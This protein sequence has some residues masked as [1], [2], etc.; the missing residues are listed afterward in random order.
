MAARKFPRTK[1]DAAVL[2]DPADWQSA[3]LGRTLWR[4]QRDILRSVLTH[5]QTA[6][7]G[8]HGS[9]KTFAA[10]GL[11]LYWLTRWQKRD[12]S[13]RLKSDGKIFNTA[14]TMRQVKLLWE[15]VALARRSS[16]QLQWMPEPYTFGLKIDEGNYGLGASSSRGVNLSGFHSGHVLIIAD[17]CPGIPSDI[18]AA[19]EG[20]RSSG[21]VRV[22]KLGN[23][24]MPLGDFFD[25]FHKD[26]PIHNCINISAFDTP[27]FIDET[28]GHETAGC[29]IT[30]EDLLTMSD[31]RLDYAPYPT[32]I[33]RRWVKERYLTW[34]PNHPSYASR[35]LG[36][37]PQQS[38]D[39]VFQLE[40]LA[41]ANR[42]PTEAEVRRAIEAG[43]PLQVGIDV[44]AEG[45]DETAACA[46]TIGGIIVGQVATADPH[47][48]P[49]IMRWLGNLRL[50]LPYSL[51][52]GNIETVVCDTVGVGYG[53][54]ES[55]TEAGFPV[56]SFKAD[57]V[58]MDRV[59]YANT[60]AEA[61]FR[62]SDYFRKGAVSGL[63]DIETVAQLSTILHRPV[64]RGQSEIVSKKDMARLHGVRRSPDRA[65]ALCMAFTRILPQFAHVEENWHRVSIS[66]I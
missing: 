11:P 60:K 29:P 15:E 20:I 1:A 64:G 56:F 40:W 53:F 6:V 52:P 38:A 23:P 51:G 16:R 18:W 50:S 27:N 13:G 25:A 46:R 12:A 37:F 4:K 47:P 17:E 10:S 24:I 45:K 65:E 14:P 57:A 62:T 59:E 36:K 35:V 30:I 43:V 61:A 41:E 54:A 48:L 39:A 7:A 32:L 3:W 22:L 44:A 34:G 49:I 2:T 9:G 33:Q 5:Q 21:Y 19:I 63:S 66:P 28:A 8:C 31:E 42:D 26:R 58:P 55:L